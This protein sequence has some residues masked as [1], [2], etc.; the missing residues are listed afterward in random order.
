MTIN[1][2]KDRSPSQASIASGYPQSGQELYAE[3]CERN[4]LGG[5]VGDT[6]A[7]KLEAFRHG[8]QTACNV[9]AA[10]LAVEQVARSI[11]FKQ[12]DCLGRWADDDAFWEAQPYGNRF[13]FG[14]GIRD[15]VPRDVLRT[16]LAVAASPLAGQDSKAKAES[17]APCPDTAFRIVATTCDP[18]TEAVGRADPAFDGVHV[19]KQEAHRLAKHWARRGY[20]ASVYSESSGECLLEVAPVIRPS[21]WGRTAS[22]HQ[23][24]PCT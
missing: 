24:S 13:Y 1:K 6:Q 15:Y 17:T 4:F 19:P 7:S 14:D 5:Y 2:V 11:I 16:I 22:R 18:R 23:E 10:A 21:G 12:Q 3:Y 9:L 20:W 8:M